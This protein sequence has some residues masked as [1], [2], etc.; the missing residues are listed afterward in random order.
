[1]SPSSAWRTL[2]FAAGSPDQPMSAVW[3]AHVSR[4]DVYIGLST[5]RGMSLFKLSLHP[6][7]WA[8]AFTES[9]GVVVAESQN[10]RTDRWERPSEFSPGWTKGPVIAVPHIPEGLGTRPERV[11]IGR[12][13]IYWT[14]APG[15]GEVLA[16]GF[17]FVRPEFDRDG[18]RW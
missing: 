3:R 17:Y 18:P 13:A 1:M 2:R 12:K 16:F 4:N 6:R 10:R 5:W 8:C 11:E 14:S 9:S 15:P 7:I